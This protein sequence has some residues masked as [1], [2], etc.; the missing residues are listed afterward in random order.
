M[1]SHDL[2][3]SYGAATHALLLMGDGKWHAGPANEVMNTEL[4]SLC[5]GYPIDMVRHGH[6]TI[7]IPAEKQHE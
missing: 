2:N 4:L 7:F 5:L 6:R 1:V 3:L